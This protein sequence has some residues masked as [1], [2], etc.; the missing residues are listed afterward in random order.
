MPTPPKLA[1]AS[2]QFWKWFAANEAHV[3]RSD[4]EH[5]TASALATALQAVSP[6]LV[7]QISHVADG[8]IRELVISA[9][10]IK[11][12]FVAVT[13]LV[14]AAPRLPGWRVI[15]FRQ[16]YPV[17]SLVISIDGLTIDPRDVTYTLLRYG[18][19]LGLRLY[20]P[21]YHQTDGR[22]DQIGFLLLDGA[23]GETDVALKLG[24]IEFAGPERVPAKSRL[25]LSEL[26]DHFDKAW[27][28]LNDRS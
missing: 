20:L 13:T 28:Q 12:A 14:A 1:A 19:E 21:D 17:G 23:L 11:S 15:A 26:P 25:P 18:K 2:T 7:F 16:R 27:L 4:G 3:S 5:E 6:D 8:G 24:A 22:F 9:D 10:G